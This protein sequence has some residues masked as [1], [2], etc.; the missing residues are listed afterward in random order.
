M[1][2]RKESTPV[3][4]PETINIP[5]YW[6][7][8]WAHEMSPMG[9]LRYFAQARIHRIADE[10]TDHPTPPVGEVYGIT[11]EDAIAKMKDRI[12]KWREEQA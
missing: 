11:P 7:D 10:G 1:T 8:I 4:D 5:G 6:I 3:H 9:G 2:K 12:R